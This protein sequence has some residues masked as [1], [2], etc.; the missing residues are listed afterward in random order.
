MQDNSAFYITPPTIFMPAKGM[1]ISLLSSD[2]E[3]IRE[4]T[5]ALEKV[6][7]SQITFYHLEGTETAETICWQM[8]YLDYSDFI[9]VNADNLTM[10]Q[11]M[12]SSANMDR[13]NLWWNIT[14]DSDTAM[15][16]LLTALGAHTYE[17]IE[18]F[19]EII[20]GSI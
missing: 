3:W 4:T 9:M 6:F 13:S 16:T 14:D 18:E 19:A 7:P 20:K 1:R 17:D 8:L 5:E 2:D 11:G 12:I 10:A 15:M